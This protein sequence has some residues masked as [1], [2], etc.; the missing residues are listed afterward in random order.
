MRDAEIAAACLVDDDAVPACSFYVQVDR[1]ETPGEF[2]DFTCR[3]E[4]RVASKMW[5][6]RN[7]KGEDM[8]LGPGDA[9]VLVIV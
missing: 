5:P 2:V 7:W 8:K 1:S 3:K 9:Y 6:P 4:K